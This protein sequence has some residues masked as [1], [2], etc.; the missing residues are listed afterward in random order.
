[1]THAAPT[2]AP[3]RRIGTVGTLS[4]AALGLALVV[5]APLVGPLSWLEAGVGLVLLPALTIGLLRLRGRQAPP[6]RWTGPAGYAANIGI[7]IALA[8]VWLQPTMLF[9]GAAMLL[10]AASGYAGCELFA[11]AN[12]VNGRDDEIGCPVFSPIDAVE[13]HRSESRGA[14]PDG[15]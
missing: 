9:Y 7:G 1:M 2:A 3:V 10:A 15:S 8:V 5:G 4:R 12:R 11:F 13:S 14:L 6:L